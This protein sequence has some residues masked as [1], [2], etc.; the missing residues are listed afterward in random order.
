MQAI[1]IMG[2]DEAFLLEVLEYGKHGA[3][4]VEYRRRRSMR[5]G[6]MPP[7]YGDGLIAGRGGGR[8]GRP[9][10][11]LAGAWSVGASFEAKRAEKEGVQRLGRRASRWVLF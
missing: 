10:G 2:I 1:P 8:C 6:P 3:K 7:G 4:H 9:K 11:G 5:A